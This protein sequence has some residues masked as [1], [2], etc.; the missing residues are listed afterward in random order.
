MYTSGSYLYLIGI[1]FALFHSFTNYVTKA[2]AIICYDI[3]IAHHRDTGA[4]R[5]AQTRRILVYEP[6]GLL[7]TGEGDGGFSL[8]VISSF[9]HRSSFQMYGY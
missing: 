1:S 9:L 4:A 6:R 7:R 5:D 2:I 8:H 3:R